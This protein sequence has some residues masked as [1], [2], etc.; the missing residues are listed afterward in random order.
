M[1]GFVFCNKFNNYQESSK[2]H[3]V[4]PNDKTCILQRMS[5]LNRFCKSGLLICFF[6]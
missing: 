1:I 4:I 6:I 5:K 3:A 2:F